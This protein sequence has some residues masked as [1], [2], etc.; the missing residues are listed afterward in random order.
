MAK[1]KVEPQSLL[2]DPKYAKDIEEIRELYR[3][4]RDA[5]M[6]PVKVW[7]K[8]VTKSSQVPQGE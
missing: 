8:P 2:T 7:I 5:G 4:L 6:E 1:V 3:L